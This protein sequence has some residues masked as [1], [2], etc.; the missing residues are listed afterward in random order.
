MSNQPLSHGRF[1]E[2]QYDNK[3][4]LKDQFVINEAE[5]MLTTLA[6]VEG[7]PEGAFDAQHLKLMHKHL[8]GDMYDWAGEFRADEL[9]VGNTASVHAVKAAHVESK[10][11]SILKASQEKPYERMTR[12]AFAEHMAGLYADL[13][14]VS[15]FPDGNAR[16]ARA[17]VDSLA[18]KHGMQISWNEVP[19]DAFTTAVDLAMNGNRDALKSI[20]A[21][22]VQPLELFDMHM[23]TAIKARTDD[24]VQRVGIKGDLLPTSQID[25]AEALTKM[26]THAKHVLVKSLNEYSQTGFSPIRDWDKSSIDHAQGNTLDRATGSSMLKSFIS[27]MD[28]GEPKNGPR[29]PNL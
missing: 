26:A 11:E 8:L 16:T 15:P 10:L 20:M 25:T 6:I 17:F 19:G 2:I 14:H 3:F 7:M 27:N 1:R 13:Y 9:L 23:L 5:S 12:L 24:L 18:E 21:K 29:S 22:V 4:G 28:T